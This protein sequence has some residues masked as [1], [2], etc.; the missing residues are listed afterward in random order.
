MNLHPTACWNDAVNAAVLGLD[1]AGA[2]T[3]L[4]TTPAPW[5]MM[6]ASAANVGVDQLLSELASLAVFELAGRTPAADQPVEEL[7]ICDA[8]DRLCCRAAMQHLFEILHGGRK[9][10]LPHWM[11]AA[12]AGGWHAPPETLPVLLD[13]AADVGNDAQLEQLL[14]VVGNRGR[15]LA[16]YN[17]RWRKLWETTTAGAGVEDWDADSRDNRL[18]TLRRLRLSDRAAALRLVEGAW[19]S[20]SAADRTALLEQFA[21]GLAADDEPWLESCLDDRSKQVRTVAAELLSRLPDSAF[22]RRMA[23]RALASVAITPGGGLLKKKPPKIDVTLP[24]EAD[25]ELKRDG[26]EP[27]M[28]R[29]MGAK[30]SLLMQI[31]ALAPLRVWLQHK[32]DEA[33]WIAA[34]IHSEWGSS[35]LEGWLAACRSQRDATWASALLTHVC[36]APTKKG[37]PVDE[38]WRRQA[39]S[40]LMEVLPVDHATAVAARAAADPRSDNANVTAL[41]LACDFPWDESLSAA[42][43]DYLQRETRSS[44]AVYDSQL[45][46]LITDAAPQ[47]LAT[48]LA[49]LLADR[50]GTPVEG[51]S[52]NFAAVMQELVSTVHFRREMLAALAP[53]PPLK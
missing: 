41:L 46:Q 31:V 39:I 5:S 43:I 11:A 25:A 30:A 52:A 6:P 24:D 35:L 22:S 48:S 36:L 3:F 37:E 2:A 4:P 44:N 42:V 47:R 27:R 21:H 45:R 33:A 29:G 19:D 50:L 38:Q 14:T 12:V 15:W 20:E 7:T 8:E 40:P 1:R 49:D 34:A 13:V 9:S 32:R 51:W 28:Q 16:E 10:L 26:V 23:E 53:S 17:P 18:A